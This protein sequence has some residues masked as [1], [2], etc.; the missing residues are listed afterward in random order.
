MLELCPC[1]DHEGLISPLYARQGRGRLH[2]AV[3]RSTTPLCGIVF[4]C[5]G[6]RTSSNS[7]TDH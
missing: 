1:D 4:P 2:G 3:H 7:G 6:E 5:N